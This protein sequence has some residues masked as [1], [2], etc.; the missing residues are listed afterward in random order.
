MR[1]ATPG[2]AAFAFASAAATQSAEGNP[3][4]AQS[5]AAPSPAV[6]SAVTQ[7]AIAA[8]TTRS[9]PCA[10]LDINERTAPSPEGMAGPSSA[11]NGLAPVRTQAPTARPPVRVHV[12]AQ[13]QGCVVWLGVDRGAQPLAQQIVSELART[14]PGA[15]AVLS[16]VCNGTTVYTRPRTPKENP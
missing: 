9:F 2:S 7:S 6:Q 11:P 14:R 16:V 13:D 3:P 15:M 5:S 8:A 10:A 1:E 12:E 4:T